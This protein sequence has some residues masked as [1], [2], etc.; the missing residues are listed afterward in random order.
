MKCSSAWCDW[1]LTRLMG[2]SVGG[3]MM[4]A[5]ALGAQCAT[6]S[7]LAR[8]VNPWR[9]QWNVGNVLVVPDNAR[10]V[11][12]WFAT[13]RKAQIDGQAVERQFDDRFEPDALFD[14]LLLTRQLLTLKE[15]LPND[16]ST[17][18]SS[19][20]LRGL[21]GGFMVVAR[22]RKGGKL[23]DKARVLM[24]QKDSTPI[25]VEMDRSSVDTLLDVSL[26]AA[27]LSAYRPTLGVRDS[28]SL[29]GDVPVK[30]IPSRRSLRYPLMLLQHPVEGE[31]WARFCVGVDGRV[32]MSTFW[33][34][35]SDDVEFEKSVKE[36]LAGTRYVP[37]TRGGLPIA[38]TVAQRFVF[39]IR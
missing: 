6:P 21:D 12:F 1:R 18:V 26:A 5:A 36:Y 11:S 29:P 28:A 15:P 27:Q 34:P 31:V 8:T 7:A 39:G 37:A 13:N 2:L 38:Q 16:T 22:I 19:G 3:L 23:S 35:L 30:P 25:M 10:G 20:Y 4:S 33:A 32:D 14:W 9:V 24:A 17:V